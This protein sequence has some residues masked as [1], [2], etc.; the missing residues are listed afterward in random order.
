MSP[1]DV[2]SLVQT[3][4]VAGFAIWVMFLMFKSYQQRSK[5]KDSE[6]LAEIEKRDARN[7]SQQKTFTDYTMRLHEST[8][9]K[10]SENT[11]ALLENT[12]VMTLVSQHLTNLPTGTPILIQNNTGDKK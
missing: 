7:E 4:G 6:L 9:G 1:I 3:T 10:L 2:Q 12:R 5:E 11:V 8:T